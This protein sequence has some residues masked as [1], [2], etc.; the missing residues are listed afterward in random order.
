MNIIIF[1]LYFTIYL[2]IYN[3]N[4]NNNLFINLITYDGIY[5]GFI[6][7]INYF[8]I[9][10]FGNIS[11]INYE[12][13]F[14]DKYIYFTILYIFY[15]F[16]ILLFWG[17]YLV[18][19]SHL[20]NLIS[21]P[22]FID[23]FIK[24]DYVA[25]IFDIIHHKINKYKI[26]IFAD[27]LAYIFNYLFS[28]ILFRNPK[29]NRY[30]IKPYLKNKKDMNNILSFIKL[31]LIN[32]LIFYFNNAKSYYGTFI[33]ILYTKKIIIN[34]DDQVL[35]DKLLDNIKQPVKRL[36]YIIDNKKFKLLFNK[37]ILDIIINLYK[38]KVNKNENGYLKNISYINI[39]IS[40]FFC[41][42]SLA[43][44]INLKVLFIGSYLMNYYEKRSIFYY[45]PKLTGTFLG[46]YTNNYI[47]LLFITEMGELFY[48]RLTKY[49][50][51]GINNKIYNNRYLLIHNNKYNYDI[52]T[53]FLIFYMIKNQLFIFFS[54]ITKNLYIY[55]WYL[56]F[57][58]FSEYNNFHL[59]CLGLTLYFSINIINY[60]NS[61][62]I[63]TS[64]KFI[65]SY[66]ETKEEVSVSPIN[67]VQNMENS[68]SIVKKDEL[69][70]I[71][72]SNYF[73]NKKDNN[74]NNKIKTNY[75]KP[76]IIDNYL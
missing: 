33:N 2:F 65:N 72:P 26:N 9:K 75:N 52:I 20:I 58:Y 49:L 16:L 50:L 10:N 68:V 18:L 11:E 66:I 51:N 47:L 29:I 5:S 56:I 59:I 19:F 40:K 21:F 73:D 46:C 15:N 54:F 41:L 43:Y 12:I 70:N 27:L 8:K 14:L 60:K 61:P 32:Y 17:N 57:G 67:C 62:N 7:L 6:F 28:L 55:L 13:C 39:L 38:V 3:I 74:I 48:N 24:L 34:V 22:C 53:N 1:L 44:F 37:K 63:I 35:D 30:D 36:N 45:I 25:K 31:L 69:I 4:F 76:N 64:Y 42:W 71:I 23:Y